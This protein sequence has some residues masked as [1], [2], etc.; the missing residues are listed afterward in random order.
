[1]KMTIKFPLTL[2]LIIATSPLLLQCASQDEVK[3]LHYQLRVVSNK[4]DTMKSNTVSS[5]QKRQASSSSQLDRIQQ[6]LLQLKSRV[7]ELSHMNRMI[8][9]QQ[10]EHGVTLQSITGR[11]RQQQE[12][13]NAIQAAR[14]KEAERKAR[15]AKIAA[16]RARAQRK[17]AEKAVTPF[18]KSSGGIETIRAQKKNKTIKYI[19]TSPQTSQKSSQIQQKPTKI[20]SSISPNDL[21]QQG[22]IEFDKKNFQKS[23][24]L[25]KRFISQNQSSPLAVK[26]RFMMGESLFNLSQYNQAIMHYQKIISNYPRNPLAPTSLLRQ[27]KAFERMSDLE[28]AKMIY[29]KIVNSYSTSSEATQAK[30][31]LEIH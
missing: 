4:V 25:Y 27:G 30:Q 3:K 11:I 29:K 8:Q 14:I 26:A 15:Q 5:I 1:M 20:V 12:A 24:T 16:E 18:R 28:T 31:L 10:K 19:A 13:K 21:M 9:E 7:E 23:F 2:I 17:Q 6:E 22:K